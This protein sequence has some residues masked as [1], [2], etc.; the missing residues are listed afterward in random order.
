MAQRL[1]VCVWDNDNTSRMHIIQFLNRLEEYQAIEYR[2]SSGQF[3]NLVQLKPNIVLVDVDTALTMEGVADLREAMPEG[4]LIGIS[5]QWPEGKQNDY[6]EAGLNGCLSKPF[7]VETFIHAVTEAGRAHGDDSCKV[8]SFFSP[9]GKSGRTTIIVNL[10]LAIARISG[11]KVAIIDA[12]TSFADMDTF[13]NLGSESTLI[14]AL[15]DLN[16]LTPGTLT[17][18]FTDV[19]DQV[20]LMCGAKNPE[21]AVFI[22]TE[23]IRK[24][25]NLAKNNFSYILI[26]L[27]QGFNPVA[28]EACEAS[29]YVY[30]T[31]MAGSAYENK[32]LKSALEIF[33][34]LDNWEQRVSCV[35]SREKPGEARQKAL[36]EDLGCPVVLIPNEYH[37]CSEAANNGRMAVDIGPETALS[38]EIN[39]WATK[40][41]Q[42]G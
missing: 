27:A 28:I 41:C 4:V 36:E 15:R 35:I 26:D 33:H 30:L 22:I 29:D 6:K 12:D 39:A 3:Q 10:A 9:K 37:L 40:I 5:R 24:L 25:I 42:K 1:R 13:L 34:S 23:E 14:E 16:Y 20:K 21:Q 32:H 18:Y 8:L 2:N 38:K 17:R 11:E 7:T 31:N 19:N